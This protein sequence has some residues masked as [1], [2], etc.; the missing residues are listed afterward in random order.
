MKLITKND[1][2]SIL[3]T[4][5]WKDLAYWQSGEWQVIE[6][7]LDDHELAHQAFVPRRVDLFRAL[8][9][10]PLEVTRCAI[11]GQDPYPTGDFATGVAFSAR[12]VQNDRGEEVLPP[13]LKNIFQE[14]S[15]DLG[16]PAPKNG[17]LTPWVKEGVLLW[18]AYPS[19][20]QG[21]PGSHHW[22]EWRGLTNEIIKKLD[23]ENMV[24]VYLGASARSFCP[25]M[26]NHV[27]IHTSHPSPMGA[28]H[29]FTGSK[30][31]TQVNT[32][33]E[34][35]GQQPINWRLPDAHNQGHNHSK[36]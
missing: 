26:G 34:Q 2:L 19:C 15:D 33:L 25:A 12:S 14:Y 9:L 16:Y 10:C 28:R 7:R 23:T 3:P 21:K 5:S 36:V 29:G 1:N 20:L 30:I 22:D 17:D 8:H 6:E 18:N 13:T 35:R 27:A 4:N 31:F 32:A 11:I 24:I